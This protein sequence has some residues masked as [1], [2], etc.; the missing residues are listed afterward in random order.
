VRWDDPAL[1]IGWPDVDGG[2]VLSAKDGAAAALA[3][4]RT[5]D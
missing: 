4:A 5:F 2:P 3:E 1:G